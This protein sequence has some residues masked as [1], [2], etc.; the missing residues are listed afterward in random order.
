MIS[1]PTIKL[2]ARLTA[3]A[4]KFKL[5]EDLLQHWIYFFTFVDSL[6]MI[7]YQ[8]KVLE[9]P[10][11]GEPVNRIIPLRE[12]RILFPRTQIIPLRESEI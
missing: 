10:I 8:Y 5:D 7:F 2:C 3:K 11:P 1:P 4:V 9:L 12:S 6:E